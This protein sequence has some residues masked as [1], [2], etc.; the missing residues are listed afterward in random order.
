MNISKIKL[1][2][3]T[4]AKYNPRKIS[5]Q[6]YK[7]LGKSIEEFGLVDPI[8]INLKTNTIIGGHQRFDYF[9]HNG[10]DTNMNLLKLGDVGWIFPDAD[11][12]IKDE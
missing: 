4:P 6:Q 5:E 9:Y 7:S 1:T 3:I 11:L 2:D 12:T 8:I 10:K